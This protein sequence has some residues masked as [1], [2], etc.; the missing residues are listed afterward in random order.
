MGK[1]QVKTSKKQF[2]PEIVTLRK[3]LNKLITNNGEG[4]KPSPAYNVN[5]ENN[6]FEKLVSIKDTLQKSGIKIT[7]LEIHFLD[8]KEDILDTLY[9]QDIYL[10]I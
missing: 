6:F 9:H 4:Y 10:P 5:I 3:E 2:S 1:R 8:G 7:N